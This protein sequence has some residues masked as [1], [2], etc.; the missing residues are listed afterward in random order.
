ML[1]QELVIANCQNFDE[2]GRES[3]PEYDL[4][5][6]PGL[7]RLEVVY[8]CPHGWDRLDPTIDVGILKTIF[9]VATRITIDI[10]H[11]GLQQAVLGS[12]GTQ[13]T[14]NSPAVGVWPLSLSREQLATIGQ[15]VDIQTP[16]MP[17]EGQETLQRLEEKLSYQLTSMNLSGETCMPGQPFTLPCEDLATSALVLGRT[18][19]CYQALATLQKL[20]LDISNLQA[21]DLTGCQQLVQLS[22]VFGSPTREYVADRRLWSQFSVMLLPSSLQRLSFSGYGA[23][24]GAYDTEWQQEFVSLMHLTQLPALRLDPCNPYCTHQPLKLNPK[25]KYRLPLLPGSIQQ[26]ELVKPPLCCWKGTEQISGMTQLTK[27]CF[28]ISE[29]SLQLAAQVAKHVPVLLPT[30]YNQFLNIK[31]FL[32]PDDSIPLAGTRVQSQASFDLSSNGWEDTDSDDECWE[33]AHCD[34]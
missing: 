25:A 28:G 30:H 21:L 14:I 11:P 31:K 5:T 2:V 4:V 19:S 12:W 9:T 8:T 24:V 7:Q 6:W 10:R 18:C 34:C 22:I 16:Y 32:R 20:D 27:L 15:L 26:L 13:C 33:C 23:L 3:W 17:Y 29:K 1:L